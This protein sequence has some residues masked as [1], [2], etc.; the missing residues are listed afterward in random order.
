[1]RHS[2]TDVE[3][4]T[5][6]QAK[7]RILYLV[8]NLG[9]V[10][11]TVLL[12]G[13]SDNEDPRVLYL[14]LLFAI[15]SS[16]LLFVARANGPYAPLVVLLAFYFLAYA[17]TD[18]VFGLLLPVMPVASGA[19]SLSL[20]EVAILSGAL[21]IMAG[22]HAAVMTARGARTNLVAAE[23][24]NKTAIVVGLAL[25]GVGVA[26]TWMWAT[27]VV[28]RY[29]ASTQLTPL[30][31]IAVTVARY[32]QPVG[33][34][35]IAYKYVVSRGVRLALLVLGILAVEFALGFLADSKEL[36]IRG[37]ALLIVAAYFVHGKVPKTWV[38]AGM[39]GL[40]VAFPVFQA[41]RFEVL[42]EGKQTR[43][44]GVQDLGKN[45]Q[46]ALQSDIAGKSGIERV[47]N[48]LGRL[49]L[50]PTMEMIVAR[51]GKDVAYQDGYTL[52]LLFYGFI[53]RIVWP[54][55]PDNSVGQLFNR[56]FSV[57]ADPNTYISATQLGEL[58]W[59]FGWMGIFVGMPLI[60]FLLGWMG[61][62]FCLA[63][64]KSITRFLVL[65]VTV[66]LICLRFEGGIAITYTQWL[67]SIAMILLLHFIFARQ[68]AVA[69]VD[70]GSE[71]PGEVE[72]ERILFPN[73]MR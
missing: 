36:S 46:T 70:G 20:T 71:S 55:K 26:A 35:L 33:V 32:A 7:R 8:L 15:C 28:D 29:I 5:A 48:A 64:H 60:G 9:F 63:E 72:R 50:K 54:D 2:D 16:T 23:W 47:G 59:N 39:V 43:T 1:M 44:E 3:A 18:F 66:Y 41:Y 37:A 49:S 17:F 65:S 13:A 57:S 67:R 51:V 42:Q 69:S 34:A 52:K 22:Y 19:G 58:Y 45:L 38:T 6:S 30:Q 40:I 12:A 25:W 24:P 10:L 4:A 21:L 53:P 56:Q 31:A 68:Q 27:E 73:L 61:A 11:L 14:C 62:R